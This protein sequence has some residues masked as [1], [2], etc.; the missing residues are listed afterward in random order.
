ME[1]S[2]DNTTPPTSTTTSASTSTTRTYRAAPS[3]RQQQLSQQYNTT[4]SSNTAPQSSSSSF[5]ERPGAIYV[6]QWIPGELSQKVKNVKKAVTDVVSNNNNNNSI[7]TDNPVPPTQTPTSS[8]TTT[9]AVTQS[10]P[11]LYNILYNV[12]KLLMYG[13]IITAAVYLIRQYI[14]QRQE[15]KQ[16][17]RL[18]QQDNNNDENCSQ[19]REHNKQYKQ[20]KLFITNRLNT[21]KSYN[22]NN[23]NDNK[24]I[25]ELSNEYNELS[26][27]TVIYNNITSILTLLF[28]QIRVLLYQRNIYRNKINELNQTILQLK[29]NNSNN[30]NNNNNNNTMNENKVDA[31]IIN[32]NNQ[33]KSPPQSQ[34]PLS[35]TSIQLSDEQNNALQHTAESEK[36]YSDPQHTTQ[37]V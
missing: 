33:N 31:T 23:D 21:L 2:L 15:K 30:N 29:Q 22:S 13:S 1:Q 10:R 37:T 5:V 9:L 14:L 35:K 28:D 18:L 3:S 12:F 24:W 27:S 11:L 4:T 20:I 16:K 17:Q 34:H 19:C 6:R 26:T 7:D 25:A 32:P 36:H 8:S